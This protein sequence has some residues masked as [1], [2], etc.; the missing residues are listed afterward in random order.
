[1]KSGHIHGIWRVNGTAT[2]V[3]TLILP[4]A[5]KICGHDNMCADFIF[6]SVMYHRC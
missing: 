1:M 6:P 4:F 5:I 2:F 3:V